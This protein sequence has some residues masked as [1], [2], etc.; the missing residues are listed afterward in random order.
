MFH[1]GFTKRTIVSEYRHVFEYESE[2]GTSFVQG[3]H[4]RGVRI[5]TRGL[6]YISAAHTDQDIA[7]ALNVATDTLTEIAAARVS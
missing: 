1:T 5:L 6:W 2:L 7:F 4:R 3:M